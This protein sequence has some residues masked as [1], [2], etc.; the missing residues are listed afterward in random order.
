MTRPKSL[1][2][3]VA[4]LGLAVLAVWVAL[5]TVAF[6][7]VLNVQLRAQADDVLRTRAQATAT[8]LDVG[9]DGAITIRNTGDDTAID[10]GTWIFAGGTAIESPRSST[11]LAQRA[12]QL[13]G[14]GTRVDQTRAPAVVRLYALPVVSQGRQVGTVVTSLSLTPYRTTE[15]LTLGASVI[16]GAA[17]LIGVYFALRASV[18]RALRPVAAM[19]EQASDWSAHDVERRFGHTD[20]P[21]ELDA[22]AVTL[23]QLLD[24]LSAVLRHERSFSGE[25]SHELRTPLARIIAE[26][27]LLRT[28]ARSQDDLDVAH[29]TIGDSAEQMS[30]ILETL[31]STAR[32]QHGAPPGRCDVGAV[33]LG[34]CDRL[35][36]ATE[37]DGG[38]PAVS[39]QVP[40]GSHVAGVDAAVLDR[41]LAPLLDNARR[42]AVRTI[43]VSVTSSRGAVTVTIEDDGPGIAEGDLLH[44]FEPGRRLEHHDGHTGAGLGL[45]LSRRLALAAG[46]T[47]TADNG[48]TGAVFSVHL[49]AG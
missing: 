42:Y 7:V 23:D 49:P 35:Q 27:S 9:A 26:T 18:A 44:V 12:A 31:M 16:L 38:V 20:R 36:G 10:V 37:A 11:E 17:L 1:R 6:N 14:R 4:L 25:L 46:G 8:T 15:E 48:P 47:V 19:T 43:R 45:S 34:A 39:V 32:S 41:I 13:T 22:L 24:R 40:P 5:I 28:R 2:S 33:V 29:A 21:T 30:L 3:R